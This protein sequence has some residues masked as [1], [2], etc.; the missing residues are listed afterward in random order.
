MLTPG[1]EHAEDDIPAVVERARRSHP[2]LTFV[3][4]WPIPQDATAAFLADHIQR[5]L[6]HRP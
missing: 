1:G 4:P 3:Y 5:A 2:E 6:R